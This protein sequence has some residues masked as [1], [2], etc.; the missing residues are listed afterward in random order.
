MG[1]SVFMEK[2]NGRVEKREMTWYLLHAVL[3]RMRDLEKK[4]LCLSMLHGIL[5]FQL[6]G[7]PAYTT[8]R[9]PQAHLL[10][11]PLLLTWPSVARRVE[12]AGDMS[13]VLVWWHELPWKSGWCG[14]LERP[15]PCH[16][17]LAEL[18]GSWVS[19]YS[20]CYSHRLLLLIQS[21]CWQIKGVSNVASSST[22]ATVTNQLCSLC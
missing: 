22:N 9:E 7:R 19:S 20:S 18:V 11:L 8:D 12:V 5:V 15:E 21:S 1:L 16:S 6:C 13:Q 2:G 10:W 4:N 14:I 17:G 3:Q